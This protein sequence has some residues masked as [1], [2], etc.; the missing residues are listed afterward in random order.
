MYVQYR[1]EN[2]VY[3]DLTWRQDGG[4]IEH[5]YIIHLIALM[6]RFFFVSVLGVCTTDFCL[7]TFVLVVGFALLLLW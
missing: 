6:A 4:M 2:N 5:I 3:I 7:L 1:E